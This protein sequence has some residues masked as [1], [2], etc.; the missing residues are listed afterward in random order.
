MDETEETAERRFIDMSSHRC[1][2]AI[3]T[4]RLTLYLIRYTFFSRGFSI[5]CAICAET[6]G[7]VT[8]AP[9][10]GLIWQPPS[11]TCIICSS[12]RE[13]FERKR[14]SGCDQYRLFYHFYEVCIFMEDSKHLS[15]LS[16]GDVI[17]IY[18]GF[19]KPV[20]KSYKT[21]V[22]RYT[23]VVIPDSTGQRFDSESGPAVVYC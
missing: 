15:V 12:G 20:S 22:Q 21:P 10:R 5:L 17:V 19:S 3:R 11:S 6:Y 2:L 23:G 13:L 4:Y 7:C 16:S 9:H 1:L 18:A 14:G 8:V